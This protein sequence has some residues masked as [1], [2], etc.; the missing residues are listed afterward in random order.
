[1]LFLRGASR[2]RVVRVLLPYMFGLLAVLAVLAFY[3][4]VTGEVAGRAVDAVRDRAVRISWELSRLAS[5]SSAAALMFATYTQDDMLFRRLKPDFT[6][7]LGLDDF[8]LVMPLEGGFARIPFGEDSLAVRA[9]DTGELQV[10]MDAG[11]A[12]GGLTLFFPVPADSAVTPTLSR[13]EL[14]AS[15]E[16][17]SFDRYRYMFFILTAV[18]IVLVIV[19]AVILRL[20]DLRRRIDLTRFAPREVAG[21]PPGT[22]AGV[23][24]RDDPILSS[25][26]AWQGAPALIRLDGEGSIADM[27]PSAL[28]LFDISYNAASGMPFQRLPGL[29]PGDGSGPP[30]AWRSGSFRVGI[31]DSSGTQRELRFESRTLA[32]GGFLLAGRLEPVPGGETPDPREGSRRTDEG[33]VAGQGS[34][35][36]P[37][38]DLAE[39]LRLAEEG[40]RNAVRGSKAA[41]CL[42]R[43]LDLAGAGGAESVQ[44]ARGEGTELSSELD[45]IALALND[46]LPERA[47]VEVDSRGLLPP[48]LCSRQDLTQLI[49]NL[50]FY[51]LESV[52]GPV[53]IRLT[54][55][56]VPSP[57]MDSVFSGRCDRSVG[58]SVELCYSDGG[59]MPVRLKEAL[60]DPETDASG[61]RRD[62]GIHITAAAAIL[63]SC[64]C[65]RVITE[66]APGTRLHV[67]LPTVDESVYAAERRGPDQ[68]GGSGIAKG[69]RV[70]VCDASRSVR[71]ALTDA[72]ESMGVDAAPAGGI[73]DLQDLLDDGSDAV[74][75]LDVSVL[76]SDPERQVT[77]ILEERPGTSIV[78][79]TRSSQPSATSRLAGR[80]GIAVLCKPYSP[81]ELMETVY[82]LSTAARAGG[83]SA[84][85]SRG[86]L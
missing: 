21:H 79:T 30:D 41:D 4:R 24:F 34:D 75:V 60:L 40:V 58:R 48:A 11:V 65:P 38:P 55:R 44:A 78:V 80:D 27:S 64:D 47:T 54:S 66:G 2:R 18:V 70:V 8:T 52:Q 3:L 7:L 19:P 73:E 76:E 31:V 49:K 68:D 20:A 17:I 12:A 39:I 82:G 51:S 56:E 9:I 10:R 59:R 81:L 13:M 43:I 29:V 22:S 45:R 33:A 85:G 14:P 16:S 83:G 25:L 15:S 5:D 72:L 42:A 36:V 74:L 23:S 67:L 35:A 46:V 37:S 26:L 63:A 86:S 61:I 50:V 69:S 77:S 1:M 71:D 62:F 53:R 6:D 32:D 57:S 84:G 28:S